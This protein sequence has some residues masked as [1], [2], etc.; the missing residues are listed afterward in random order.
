MENLNYSVLMSVYKKENPLFLKE[1]IESILNQT[2]LTD[3]FVLVCDGPLTPDLYKIIRKFENEYSMIFHVY[4][5][6]C[7]R[8]LGAALNFGLCH[9]KNEIVA[10]MDSD[11]ISVR[12]RCEKQIKVM[13]E[14]KVDLVGG[15]I[16]EFSKTIGDRE[17][18]KKVPENNEA[19]RTYAKRRNPFNHPCVMYK[20]SEIL[21]A[22]GYKDFYLLEDYYLWIRMI[23]NNAKGYNIPEVLLYMRT[24]AGMYRRRGGLK[25]YASVYKLCKYKLRMG[26]CNLFEFIIL[27]VTYFFVCIISDKAR[28]AIYCRLL[29][30]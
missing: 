2:V 5:L 25:Y 21:K 20:K 7:N 27:T 8:G 19:I 12:N 30:R 10:R 29:R 24:G 15:Y 18:I 22:G 16:Q 4:K 23:I 11:D 1:S 9:C 17:I 28:E 6:E 14:K 13:A 26:F 3:D